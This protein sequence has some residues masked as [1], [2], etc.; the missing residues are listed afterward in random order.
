MW[1]QRSCCCYL[2]NCVHGAWE[3]RIQ[4]LQ[5]LEETKQNL[6]EGQNARAGYTTKCSKVN[7]NHQKDDACYKCPEWNL[8]PLECISISFCTKLQPEV[9]IINP[10]TIFTSYTV[11]PD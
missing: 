9:F 4:S 6:Q 5:Q 8:I 10:P 1:S 2:I 7:K 11:A 3:R